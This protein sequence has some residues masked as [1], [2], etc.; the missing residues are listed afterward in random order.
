MINCKGTNVLCYIKG[1]GYGNEIRE[2]TNI[3][4]LGFQLGL[5]WLAQLGWQVGARPRLTDIYND[6]CPGPVPWTYSIIWL[7]PS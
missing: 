2:I 4:K 3:N 6:K 1:Y 5:V 7:H